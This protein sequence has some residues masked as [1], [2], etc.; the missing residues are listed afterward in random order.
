[1]NRP[2]NNRRGRCPGPYSCRSAFAACSPRPRVY[3]PYFARLNLTSSPASPSRR[4]RRS[5]RLS[6]LQHFRRPPTSRSAPPNAPPHSTEGRRQGSQFF[7]QASPPAV[8]TTF[9]HRSCSSTYLSR[10]PVSSA[11][12]L[13][14]DSRPSLTVAA[15]SPS[16]RFYCSLPTFTFKRSAAAQLSGPAHDAAHSLTLTNRVPSATVKLDSQETPPPLCYSPIASDRGRESTADTT[17]ISTPVEQAASPHFGRPKKD[18]ELYFSWHRKPHELGASRSPL[19]EPDLLFEDA[20]D[21]S[22]PLFTE[23]PPPPPPHSTLR[24]MAQT[25]GPI[26]ITTPPRFG[27]NSPQNQTSNLTSALREAGANRDQSATSNHYNASGADVRNERPGI[28]GRQDSIS[29]GLGSSLYG[30][31]A[32]PISMKDRGR[33]ES[34]TM[35]SFAGGMSWGGISVGS[36][37][38]DDILMAGTSPA[39]FNTQSP[40]YHSSSYLPKMEADFMRDFTCCGLTLASLHD[41]L[42]HFEEVH[43]GAPPSRPSQPTTQSGLQPTMGVATSA[44]VTPGHTQNNGEPAT[45]TQLGFHP[46][47]G[48]AGASGAF[49]TQRLGSDGFSR[50]NLSTVHDMDSLEDMEMDDIGDGL[51]TIEEAPPAFPAQQ[52]QFNQN[53]SQLQPLNV[54][55]AN[56]MQSHQ[57]LRTSTPTTPAASQQFNLQNNPTVSSVNTPTLGTVPMQSTHNLTSPDSSHPSTP[58]ELDMDFANNFGQPMMGMQGMDMNFGNVNFGTGMPG[59]DGTIDQPGKRLFSKQGAGLSQQQLQAA[60]KNYQMGG[61]QNELTRRLQQQQLANGANVPQFPFPE[62]V[63]PFRCPVIGCEKAYKNQNGL[64]YHK[65]HGHQNQQLK[66]NEDGTFSIVDPLT[67]IPYPGTVGMEKEKPYRC[68]MCGKRYKNL[69]GL[70]YHRAHAPRCNPELGQ[71]FGQLPALQGLNVGA[72]VA[73]AGMTGMD[74]SMF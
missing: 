18:S 13:Y 11:V 57:G 28:G 52:N 3:R 16:L 4:H 72:N 22:F 44:G 29:N 26:D 15:A 42:Q 58:A 6:K 71:Q 36:W 20:G 64:K 60:F 74:T 63:K 45:H 67:S 50:T 56:T 39:A 31:A 69:N 53:Q 1:M 21:C 48:S 32:R 34:V 25:A 9:R 17:P 59:F 14:D 27:S 19:F 54:N 5:P 43:A 33:R 66:E 73:G 61:D 40:S 70:K 49:R 37:I 23:Q 12:P 38:R 30:S 2:C 65:Q 46:R 41:V 62:E 47:S 68:E 35:G 7:A 24:D 10:L 51:A 8:A 55:L